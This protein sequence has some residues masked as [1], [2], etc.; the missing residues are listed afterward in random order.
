MTLGSKIHA[1]RKGQY[2]QKVKLHSIFLVFSLNFTVLVENLI[3][4]VMISMRFSIQKLRNSWLQVRIQALLWHRNSSLV[5]CTNLQ[6][7]FFCRFTVVGDRDKLN[8]CNDF[9]GVLYLKCGIAGSLG[10]GLVWGQYGYIMNMHLILENFN[11]FLLL[12]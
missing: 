9:H 8:T 1:L 12:Y 11:F 7:A 6:V 4:M 3:C 5:K 2:D 10:H